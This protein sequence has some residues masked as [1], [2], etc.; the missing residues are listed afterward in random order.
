MASVAQGARQREALWRSASRLSRFRRAG[1]KW[2]PLGGLK[3]PQPGKFPRR[4]RPR[5]VR[6]PNVAWSMDGASVVE[7]GASAKPTD[8]RQFR[9]A[10]CGALVRLSLQ[11]KH[12][13]QPWQ[14]LRSHGGAIQQLQAVVLH[15]PANRELAP[16]AVGLPAAWPGVSGGLGG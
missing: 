8:A 4:V 1:L 12:P 9:G 14:Y 5:C 6:H 10:L 16:W 15:S 11:E 7:G 3:W 2:L 13:G